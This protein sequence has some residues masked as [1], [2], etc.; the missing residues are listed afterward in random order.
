MPALPFGD[1]V[2]DVAEDVFLILAT[3]ASAL[4][5][6]FYVFEEGTIEL[7]LRV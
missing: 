6:L 4:V 1:S 3:D 7:S 5:L 2:L